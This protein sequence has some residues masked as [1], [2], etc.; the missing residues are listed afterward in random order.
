MDN[1]FKK[2]ESP[3]ERLP[4]NMKKKVMNDV[5][6]FKLFADLASLFSSNYASVIENFFK[7]RKKK[8]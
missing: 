6:S 4:E 8:K 7:E 3:Q 2:L 5:A 1:P